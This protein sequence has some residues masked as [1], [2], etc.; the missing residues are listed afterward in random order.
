M[1]IAFFTPLSPLHTAVADHSEGLLPYL[2]ELVDVDLF[3]DEGYTPSSPEIADRFAIYDYRDFPARSGR[4]DAVLYAMGSN[5]GFHGYIYDTLLQFPG[6]VI[7]HDTLLHRTIINLTIDRGRP[8]AYLE[9]MRHAYGLADFRIAA[10]IESGYGDEYARRYP[11]FERLVDASLGVIVHNDH[12]RQRILCSR[13]RARVIQINQHFFLPPGFPAQTDAATLRR[14]WDL[15]GRFVVGSFG[16]FVPDK[17]LD[18]CLRAFAR[19][20]ERHPEAAYLLVGQQARDYDLPGLIHGLGLDDH[21]VLTGWMD[22]VPFTQHM[23]LL[24]AGI[25]LRYPH[26]GGTPF[27]PIRLMGLGVPTLLSDIEPLAG[28]PEGTCAKIAPDEF[29]EDT[30]L[31]LLTYL[32]DHEDVRRQL[33]QHGADWIRGHHDAAQIAAQYV[34][35]LEQSRREHAP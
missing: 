16:L 11:L 20:R 34:A 10:R 17:R 24:D 5:A 35:A 33:G 12:A 32:A 30:L 26:V 1:R 4:Y 19:F 29:E 27:T 6:L 8:E 3:I 13:P 25:H 22:P 31:A 7:L 9:E 21:V 18:V 23:H 2:A 15:E 14:R 28:L